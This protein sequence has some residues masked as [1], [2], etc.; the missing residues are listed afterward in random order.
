MEVCRCDNSYWDDVPSLITGCRMYGCHGIHAL[1][2][3]PAMTV[4]VYIHPNFDLLGETRLNTL[5]RCSECS[6]GLKDPCVWDLEGN[7]TD[8]DDESMAKRCLHCQQTCLS[9]KREWIGNDE[10]LPVGGR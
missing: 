9:T 10:D 2:D 7:V 5:M 8:V 6:C 1:E 3:C 4:V